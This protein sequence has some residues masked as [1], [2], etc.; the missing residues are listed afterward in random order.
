MPATEPVLNERQAPGMTPSMSFREQPMIDS[1]DQMDMAYPAMHGPDHLATEAPYGVEKKPLLSVEQPAALIKYSPDFRADSLF[2][3]ALHQLQQGAWPQ[4]MLMLNVLKAKYPDAQELELLAQDVTLKTELESQWSMKVKGRQLGFAPLQVLARLGPIVLIA[5]LVI[6]GFFSY[7][8]VQRARGAALERSALQEQAQTALQSGAYDEAINLF[9]QFL[10]LVPGDATALKGIVE[11]H[12][13]IDLQKEYKLAVDAMK[14]GNTALALQYFADIEAKAAG[15]LDVKA[16]MDKIKG[17]A[18]VAQLFTKAEAAYQGKQW[19]EAIQ[20]YEG[21]RQ[22][23][24]TYQA[25]IVTSHLVDAYLHAGQQIVAQT[26]SDTSDPKTAKEYFSKVLKLKTTEPT[27]QT[28]SDLVDSYLKGINSIEQN[29]AEEAIQIFQTVY[30]ARP[31]YVGGYVAEQLYQTYLKLGREA[32]QAGNLWYALTSFSAAS[33]LKVRDTSEATRLLNEVTLALTPTP[34]TIPTDV[35]AAP[36][37]P[38][39]TATPIPPKLSD[40]NGWIIFKSDRE[41]GLGVMR[42]DGSDP[43]V[44]PADAAAQIAAI[45]EKE[46]W[47]PDHNSHLYVTKSEDGTNGANIFKLRA[48][49][50]EN[51]Q[52]VFTYTDQSGDEYDP[53]WSP[54]N[55]LIA[56]VANGT[57][58]DEIW[59]MNSDG[60]G[61]KQLTVNTWEWDKHPTWSPDGQ[62]IVFYS[63]RTGKRQ[64]W[65]M[66]PDGSAQTLLSN[67]QFEEWD[68]IWIK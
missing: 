58:N 39:P 3:D 49:L 18:D 30:Q 64:L 4:A 66:N 10:V 68:P 45:Y 12:K 5:V 67:G 23:S 54:D 42:P 19:L 25:D 41:G 57:G 15:Y 20:Q 32:Q 59:V 65:S 36:V 1:L 34:T 53:V 33:E 63:N 26:P 52:R 28:E 35:P 43:Q 47:S 22:V 46:S 21:L 60:T 62:K 56:Y 37:A 13:Q 27:A 61:Q 17:T 24:G 29:N 40:F 11:A 7:S 50:P 14:A 38:E 31:Q 55:K 16:L 8:Y 44:A 51:W 2:V 9:N 6:G 48:D